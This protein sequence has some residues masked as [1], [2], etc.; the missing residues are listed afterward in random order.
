VIE[1]LGEAMALVGKA[2]SIGVAIS[3]S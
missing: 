3:I 2:A 1:G